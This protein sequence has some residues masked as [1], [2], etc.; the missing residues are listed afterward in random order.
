MSEDKRAADEAR[1]RQ[2]LKTLERRLHRWPRA[3]RRRELALAET[4]LRDAWAD[5]GELAAVLEDFGDPSTV[6]EEWTAARFS[7]SKTAPS[8]QPSIV[9]AASAALRVGG[10]ILIGLGFTL[11][12]F[13]ALTAVVR[14]A[15]PEFAGLYH[16][17]DGTWRIGVAPPG[18]DERD[19]LGWAYA[20]LASGVAFALYAASIWGARRLLE[21]RVGPEPAR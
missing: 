7:E 9:R 5:R 13:L 10:W 16:T 14:W 6:A 3:A 4:H 2:Y 19:V 1:L 12:T 18:Q 20:P 8:P 17:A 11:A 15:A 21:P